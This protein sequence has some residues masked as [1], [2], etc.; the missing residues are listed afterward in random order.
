MF[1]RFTKVVVMVIAVATIIAPAVNTSTAEAGALP[2]FFCQ[3]A[4][5]ANFQVV[6]LNW[7]CN[8]MMAVNDS[9][10]DPMGDPFYD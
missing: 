9:C 10:C 6:A 8:V 2:E 1:N 3:M 7:V 5:M 4:E